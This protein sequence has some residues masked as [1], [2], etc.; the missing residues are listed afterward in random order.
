MTVTASILSASTSASNSIADVIGNDYLC[1]VDMIHMSYL[2][3]VWTGVGDKVSDTLF[4]RKTPE[5]L[6]MFYKVGR[7]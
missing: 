3:G 5:V 1:V 6:R 4:Y 7:N 2:L